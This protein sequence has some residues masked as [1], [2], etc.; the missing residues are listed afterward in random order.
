MVQIHVTYQ[1]MT[2]LRITTVPTLTPDQLIGTSYYL[3][4]K[5]FLSIGVLLGRRNHSGVVGFYDT[6]LSCVTL[7][8]GLQ[9]ISAGRLGS[10][11]IWTD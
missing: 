7:L 6:L 2:T 11:V 9:P 4:Y 8:Y 1:D 5:Y 3:Y 10:G